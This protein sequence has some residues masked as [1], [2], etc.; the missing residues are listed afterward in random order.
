MGCDIEATLIIYVSPWSVLLAIPIHDLLVSDFTAEL[1]AP[2]PSPTEQPAEKPAITA[3]PE[4][5]PELPVQPL[6]EPTPSQGIAWWLILI[7]VVCGVIV[8]G[9]GTYFFM[10]IRRA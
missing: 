2:A 3:Q 7:Y 10:R 8:I 5:E 6:V 1:T 4:K 9:L